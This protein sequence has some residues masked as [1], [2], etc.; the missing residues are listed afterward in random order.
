ME[1]SL[2]MN[3]NVIENI[4]ETTRGHEAIRKSQLDDI[5]AVINNDLN[6]KANRSHVD[7]KLDTK[8]N[9]IITKDVNLSNKQLK[10]LGYNINDPT[11][12]VNL[13]FTDSKYLQKVSDSD[14]NMNEYR[15]VNSLDPINAKDLSTKYYVDTEITKVY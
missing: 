6:D 7:T 3:N 5:L 13:G 2:D 8:L 1:T 15:V 12:V 10:N 4:A 11:D 14:L 9:K